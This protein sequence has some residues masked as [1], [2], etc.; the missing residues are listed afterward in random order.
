MILFLNVHSSLFRVLRE[1]QRNTGKS[2]TAQ[3]REALED[4]IEVMEIDREV[5]KKKAEDI[6]WKRLIQDLI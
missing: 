5:E 4:H 1:V 2:I 3:I 6:E